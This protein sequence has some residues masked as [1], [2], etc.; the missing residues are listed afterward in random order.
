M[1]THQTLDQEFVIWNHSL[2]I[3]AL[4]QSEIKYLDMVAS[5]D[6]PPVEWIWHEMDRE[7]DALHLDNRAPL[8]G[9]PIGG[10]YSHP[11][12]IINGVFTAVDPASV[13]HRDAIAEFVN[14]INSKY[15][16]DYGGGFGELAI[17]LQAI[18]PKIHVEIVEP[19]PS[20]IG[21]LRVEGKAGIQFTHELGDQY[22]CVIAQDV[23]E[24]VEK[25]LELTAKMVKATKLG[26]Y[27]IFANCFY[28]VIKC[29]L[30]TTFYLRHTFTWVM[31][32]MGLKFE[33]RVEGAE[34]ALIFKRVGNINEN[35]FIL[36]N[37][38]SKLIGPLL[39]IM[40][41]SYNSILL[42]LGKSRV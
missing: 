9:Q 18:E 3:G 6:R 40:F 23:L 26:G 38:T 28:P 20:K 16:A 5:Q 15:V 1:V 27:L 41:P 12:W 34:H 39:N 22:D 42:I 29:H 31:R 37:V 8:Q 17:K 10:F 25:P 2:P 32:T 21:M 33:G 4:Q 11:V 24:H 19:Y 36:F 13:K 7:W 30:P 35:L 14:S